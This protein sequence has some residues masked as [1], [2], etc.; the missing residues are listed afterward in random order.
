MTVPILFLPESLRKT[1][2]MRFGEQVSIWTAD[3]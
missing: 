1:T 3:Q 2:A